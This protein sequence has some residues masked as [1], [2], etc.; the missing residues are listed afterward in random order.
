MTDEKKKV[1]GVKVITPEDYL[2]E[3][4]EVLVKA[5]KKS[6]SNGWNEAVA[7]AFKVNGGSAKFVTSIVRGG[8]TKFIFEA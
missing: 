3:A 1:S 5:G 6:P 2:L 7:L 8:A 4:R